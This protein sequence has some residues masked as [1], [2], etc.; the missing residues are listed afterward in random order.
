MREWICLGMALCVGRPGTGPSWP[1]ECRSSRD[2]AFYTVSVVDLQWAMRRD[3]K[4]ARGSSVPII[5]LSCPGQTTWRPRRKWPA[6]LGSY[7]NGS[8]ARN[9]DAYNA[10]KQ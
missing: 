5:T 9:A 1:S 2:S 4:T 6:V 3:S 10:V 7:F 8:G